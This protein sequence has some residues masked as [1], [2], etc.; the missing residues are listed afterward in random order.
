MPEVYDTLPENNMERVV[1]LL[2]SFPHLKPDLICLPELFLEISVNQAVDYEKLTDMCRAVL[3]AKAK[4]LGSYIVAGLH[5]MIDGK[6]YNVAWLI[7]RNGELAGRYIKYH[8]VDY[9]MEK[10]VYPGSEIPVFETDFGK[11]GIL[12]CFDIDWP[13]IWTEMGNQGAEMVVWISAYEGGYPLYAYAAG[14][15]YYVVSSVRANRS[16]IIDK[17]GKVLETSSKWANWAF[18]QIGMD[19]T[20]FHIDSQFPKLIRLQK[21]LGQKITLETYEEEGRFMI[22]SND[23]DWPMDRIIKEY[24]LVTFKEYHDRVARMNDSARA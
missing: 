7:D 23:P 16:R 10:G 8:P 6:L 19:K 17:S 22:E 9:E 11:L 4:Q 5:E 21:E 18:K 2:D 12:I 14:N 24:A 13:D 1:T 20:M 15:A 3:F